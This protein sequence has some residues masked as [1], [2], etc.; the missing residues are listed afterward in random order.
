MVRRDPQPERGAARIPA[1]MG[2]GAGP[3]PD[4]ATDRA[5]A[6]IDELLLRLHEHHGYDFR[7]YARPSLRRRIRKRMAEEE[8]G[9]VTALQERAFA[10]ARCLERLVADLSIHV[11]SMFRDPPVYLALRKH[12]IPVL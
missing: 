5:D 8:V 1:G 3:E 7:G 2:E 10:D 11:T 4:A 12:V 9:S 6:E